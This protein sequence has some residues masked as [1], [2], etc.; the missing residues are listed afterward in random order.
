MGKNGGEPIDTILTLEEALSRFKCKR[1]GVGE[2]G[3]GEPPEGS[4]VDY[5]EVSA[6]VQPLRAA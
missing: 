5:A 3:M 6:T 4:G 1:G 2:E